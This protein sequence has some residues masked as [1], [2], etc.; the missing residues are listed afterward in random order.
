MWRRGWEEVCQFCEVF[1][2]YFLVMVVVCG[3]DVITGEVEDVMLCN[4]VVAF[5]DTNRF[6][7]LLFYL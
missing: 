3:S 5:D 7:L 2:H 4:L 6:F 1:L